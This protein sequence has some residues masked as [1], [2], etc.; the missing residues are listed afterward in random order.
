MLKVVGETL[1]MG[2]TTNVYKKRVE[3]AGKEKFREKSLHRVFM[4]DVSEVAG[5]RS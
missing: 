3:K 2:G 5:E 4:R 1:Q